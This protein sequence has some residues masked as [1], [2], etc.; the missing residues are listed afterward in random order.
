MDEERRFAEEV[1]VVLSGIG[2]P[3]AFGK[4][5]GRLLICDP[6]QQSSAQLARSLGLSKGSVSTGMRA[7]EQVGM[8]RR[9]PGAGRGHVYEMLPDALVRTVDAR[10]VYLAIHALMQNG[11]DLLGGDESLPRAQ[12]LRVSRDFY[13]FMAERIPQLIDE[14]ARREGLT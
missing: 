7:L 5:M 4:L 10:R 13:A 14:F 3:A 1:G 11:I 8:V 9:V 6:P 2:L 12:R